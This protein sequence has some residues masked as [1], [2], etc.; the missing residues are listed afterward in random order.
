MSDWTSRHSGNSVDEGVVYFLSPTRIGRGMDLK[1]PLPTPGVRLVQQNFPSSSYHRTTLQAVFRRVRVPP[2]DAINSQ[3]TR[4]RANVSLSDRPCKD[5]RDG[6]G[7][8]F[9][10]EEI[11]AVRDDERRTAYC[12]CSR[13]SCWRRTL[14]SVGVVDEL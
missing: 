9:C 14:A 4:R 13:G 7:L 6:G 11:A 5:V 12:L 10:N 2:Y 3:T 8:W 1:H